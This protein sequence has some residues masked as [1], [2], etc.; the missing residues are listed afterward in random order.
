MSLVGRNEPCPCGSG[1]KFKRCCLK[2]EQPRGAY[3]WGER[4]SA[5]EKLMRFAA[6]SEFKDKHRAA[7]EL[8]WGDWLSEGPDEEL[9][10]VMIRNR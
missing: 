1:L 4:D 7:L 10:E 6:R 2:K 9:K 3:M 8:F 5:L